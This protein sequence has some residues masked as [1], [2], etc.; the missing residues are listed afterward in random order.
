MTRFHLGRLDLQRWLPNG[1]PISQVN[2]GPCVYKPD[3]I[4]KCK[5]HLALGPYKIKKSDPTEKV[6]K[7]AR[8]ILSTL[9][10]SNIIDNKAKKIPGFP[11]SCCK[12]VGRVGRVFN[13]Y[14]FFFFL[15]FLVS[16]R[17]S[18]IHSSLRSAHLQDRP[19]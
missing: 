8:K 13:F 6:K 2:L 4:N 9:K 18:N 19:P 5:Y 11:I 12:K 16:M 17:D 14:L 1:Q 7:E 3:Y 15:L 10:D